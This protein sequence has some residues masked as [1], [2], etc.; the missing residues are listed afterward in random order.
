MTN[1]YA[2]PRVRYISL[3][4][5]CAGVRNVKRARERRACDSLNAGVRISVEEYVEMG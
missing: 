5:M 3:E 1:Q 4:R 2:K